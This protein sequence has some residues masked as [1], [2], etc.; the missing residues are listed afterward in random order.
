MSSMPR[1]HPSVQRVNRAYVEVP[2]SPLTI[3]RRVT[4]SGLH[5]VQSNNEQKENTPLKPFS[6]P[7]SHSDAPSTSLKRKLLD[8]EPSS[9]ILESIILPPKKARLSSFSSG[10]P[11]N[12][13][14]VTMNE[15]AKNISEEF[16]NG[17][18]YCHQCNKRRDLNGE[19]LRLFHNLSFNTHIDTI[20]CNSSLECT[21]NSGSS[22][23]RPCKYKYCRQC[24][25]NRYNEDINTHVLQNA[26]S[27]FK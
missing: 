12:I 22:K 3:H 6:L 27:G 15:P 24:L 7:M 1:Q 11:L 16:P 25:K 9:L 18:V 8:R 23:Q 5:N 19:H 21:T 20:T 4:V 14:Q 10:A 17:F 2:P 26:I 13:K